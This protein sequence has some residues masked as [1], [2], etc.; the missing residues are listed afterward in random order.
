MYV[1]I[2]YYKKQIVETCLLQSMTDEV[3]FVR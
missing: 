2:Y 3:I 1:Y